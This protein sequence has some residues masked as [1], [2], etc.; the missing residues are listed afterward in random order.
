MTCEDS[1][2]PFHQA[3]HPFLL[4]VPHSCDLGV[5]HLALQLEDTVHKSLTGG[6]AAGNVDIDGDNSVATTDDAVAVVVVASS[7]GAA[8]HR[9]HPARIG[10]LIVDLAQGRGHLIGKGTG[11][12]HDVGLT[13]RGTEDDSESVLIVSWRRQV[14]HFDGAASQTKGHGP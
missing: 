13:G 9:N 3:F 14:H 4:S 2:S 8:T 10:H 5:P 6:W 12:N 11:D 1:S 7:V